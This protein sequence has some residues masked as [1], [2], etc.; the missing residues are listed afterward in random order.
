MT[1][2]ACDQTWC[3]CCLINV[4]SNAQFAKCA[5]QPNTPFTLMRFE[6]GCT[7]FSS[8]WF[9]TVQGPVFLHRRYAHGVITATWLF[10][11]F[12]VFLIAEH[13][14]RSNAITDWHGWHTVITELSRFTHG[15][16]RLRYVGT[17]FRRGCTRCTHE[18][19]WWAHRYLQIFAVALRIFAISTRVSQK[20]YGYV[21]DG[22]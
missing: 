18:Y 19:T 15:W 8:I 14:P 13:R 5:L 7:R 4:W 10:L 9:S 12:G 2:C 11:R 20:H 3:A 22:V 1:R 16:P 17:L 6:Y 21:I